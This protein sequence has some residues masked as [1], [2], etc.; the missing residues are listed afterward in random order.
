MLNP[1]GRYA[2]VG[3]GETAV[4]KLPDVTTYA[5]TLQAVHRALADAGLKP[6]DVDG[7]ICDP[8][9]NIPA[10]DYALH[11]AHG[12]GILPTFATDIAM[13]GA[14]PCGAVATAIMAIES[15][16][17]NTVVCLHAQ[18]QAT[19]RLEPRRGSL[20]DGRED[21]EQ[22]FG[23]LGAPARHAAVA[24]RHMH[25]YGTTSEQLAAVAVAFRK[26]ACLNATAMMRKPITVEDVVNSR[27]ICKPFHLLDCCLVSDGA[28]AVVV[29]TAE[30]ARALQTRPVY[31]WGF[32]TGF[33]D[34]LLEAEDVTTLGGAVSSQAAYRMAGVGPE[35]IQF[36]EVY[37]CFTAIAMVTIEDYGFCK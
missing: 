35:D 12:A 28:G 30:R 6:E 15:G 32:G 27:W 36:A 8:P 14:A 22:P 33:K 9:N 23:L 21:F 13:G 25:Q 34:D 2:I 26:H 29:T 1:K 4:G 11:V 31:V 10:R 37:D 17:A 5:L 20:Y 19:G 16:L 18:K 3:V 24:A 7:V